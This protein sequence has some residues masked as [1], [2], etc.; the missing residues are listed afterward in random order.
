MNEEE[1]AELLKLLRFMKSNDKSFDVNRFMSV[2]L[3]DDQKKRLE[4]EF[5][6]MKKAMI[7]DFGSYNYFENDYF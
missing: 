4:K 5:G 2:G 3:T 1:F 6:Y 7:D